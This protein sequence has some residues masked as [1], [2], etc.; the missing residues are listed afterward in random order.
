MYAIAEETGFHPYFIKRWFP[1][2]D[3][4]V[5]DEIQIIDGHGLA[6]GR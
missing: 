4:F 1:E 3:D 2:G 6:S 5:R